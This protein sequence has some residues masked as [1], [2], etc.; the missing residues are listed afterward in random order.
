[1]IWISRA[2]TRYSL[3][4]PKRPEATCL[5]AL[6]SGVAVGQRLEAGRILAAFAGVRLGAE[7]VHGDGQR[8]WASLRDRAVAHRAGLEALDDRFDRL[9]LVEKADAG[10]ST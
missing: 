2:L 8:S 9:D 3:V 4:T 6:L 7:P 10:G 5:M 1:L